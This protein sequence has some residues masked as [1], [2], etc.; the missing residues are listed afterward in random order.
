MGRK[1]L[2][3]HRKLMNAIV[4]SH[5]VV[6]IIAKRLNVEWHTANTAIKSDPIALQAF[7]DETDRLVD[8]AETVI[9]NALMSED[10]R[11]AQWYLERKGMR[12]GYNPTVK[13]KGSPTE[14]ITLNFIDKEG[15]KFEQE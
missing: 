4:E 15:S 14:P 10:I 9:L 6:S 7:N 12:R 11:V 1:K 13:V 3:T 2:V 5:G 8:V